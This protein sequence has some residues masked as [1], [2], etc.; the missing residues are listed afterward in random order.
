MRDETGRPLGLA[1]K[2]GITTANVYYRERDHEEIVWQLPEEP[3]KHLRLTRESLMHV[4]WGCQ[5]AIKAFVSL[6]EKLYKR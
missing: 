6:E 2:N 3:S 5:G 1:H 4:S